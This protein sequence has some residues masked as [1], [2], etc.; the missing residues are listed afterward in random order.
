MVRGALRDRTGRQGPSGRLSVGDYVGQ[1]AGDAAQ[2]VRR[3]GLRPGLERL[4]GCDPELVGNVVAQEPAAGDQLARNGLVVLYVAA[5]G[6]APLEKESDPQPL[7]GAKAELAVERHVGVDEA[8]LPPAPTARSRRKAGLS[9]TVLTVFDTA[10]AP[11][12]PDPRLDVEVS[13]ADSQ[14]HQ[15]GTA[16]V[17]ELPATEVSDGPSAR[18]V[19]DET[20]DELSEE[21]LVVH[22]DDVFAGRSG[23]AWPR[24]YPSRRTVWTGLAGVRLGARLAGHRWLLRAAAGALALWLCVGFAAALGRHSAAHHGARASTGVAQLARARPLG[25]PDG[26]SASRT[27]TVRVKSGPAQRRSRARRRA[28]TRRDLRPALV[29]DEAPG[30]T[31]ASTPARPTPLATAAGTPAVQAQEQTQGGPFSP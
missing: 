14:T 31:A 20:G 22:A 27:G 25:V 9:Q 6:A 24:A 1:P 19:D 29:M 4:F 7:H 8:V 3:A 26:P 10:P 23:T 17:D 21:E 2:A 18:G 30:Q 15:A 13:Q 28:K 16:A 12:L 11:T 5:P